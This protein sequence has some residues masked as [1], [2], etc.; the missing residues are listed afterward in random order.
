MPENN[1]MALGEL[2]QLADE[3][4]AMPLNETDKERL[5]IQ[6]TDLVRFKEAFPEPLEILR[7]FEDRG[8]IFR[9]GEQTVSVVFHEHNCR[10]GEMLDITAPGS[11]ESG[12]LLW[13]VFITFS[14]KECCDKIAGLF[15]G[16]PLKQRCN[17]IYALDY[18][19]GALHVI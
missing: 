14:G 6:A 11:L 3:I 17:S 8:V 9:A 12:Q 5:M 18:S 2:I 19:T 15:A 16:H 1:S 4:D 10:T 7:P 13:L